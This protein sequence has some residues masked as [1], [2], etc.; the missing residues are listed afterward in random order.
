M[1]ALFFL[2]LK[3][4]PGFLVLFFILLTAVTVT[5]AEGEK[6]VTKQYLVKLLGTRDGWPDN[7]TPDEEKIMDDHYNYLKYLVKKNKVLIAGPHFQPVFGLIILDVA[8]EE[9]AKAIMEKE[10]SVVQGVHTY[11][12]SELRVSLFADRI[13]PDRYVTDQADKVLYKEITVP[14]VLEEVWKCWTTTTGVESF[15]SPNAKIELSPGGPYEVYFSMDA[16]EGQRG[17]ELCRVLS[18]LPMQML[19]FEWNAPPQ[20]GELRF[21]HTRVIILFDELESGDVRIRF[22][23]IGWGKGEKW[24]KVYDYFDKA[25]GYVLSNLEKRFNEGPIKW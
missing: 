23:H 6:I 9:E 18:Y 22:Y 15:F 14:A 11:E 4:L 7:M 17:S 10:P 1:K 12:I 3:I 8:S 2:T 25:W 5:S 19:S 21:I 16:P 13:A 20:F 24:D